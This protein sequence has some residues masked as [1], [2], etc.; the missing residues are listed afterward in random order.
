MATTIERAKQI[1]H[2]LGHSWYFRFWG[3]FWFIFALVTFSALIILSKQAKVNQEH[4]DIE[5]F[6]ENT[7]SIN[8]PRFH[9]RVDHRGNETFSSVVCQTEGIFL[10]NQ[11]C[12]S[13]GGFIPPMSQCVAI[14]GDTV[15][16]WNDRNRNDA[17]IY[18]T[19]QTVGVPYEGNGMIAWE[20]DGEHDMHF[21]G[22]PFFSTVFAPNDNCWLILEK[23]VL[24]SSKSEKKW[25]L[26]QTDLVYHSTNWQPKYY[27]LTTIM[28]TFLVRHFEPKDVYNGWMAVGNIGG[29]AFFMVIIH[30]IL[31]IV[32]GLFLTNNSTFL[33]S[34]S[35]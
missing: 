17:R 22:N 21:S 10:T 14:A 9:F 23:N 5:M 6:V 8:F 18:C 35:E 16:A 11:Q 4:H 13:F 7:T 20:L 28:G 25:D 32:F 12:S 1:A 34:S 33:T 24:Q 29:V 26:W 2:D 19:I 31:M 15:T 27:N 30:T 3:L